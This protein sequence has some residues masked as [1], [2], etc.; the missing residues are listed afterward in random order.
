LFHRKNYF[1]NKAD[2]ARLRARV[3]WYEKGEQSTKYFFNLERKNGQNK[4]WQK[5][6]GL[7]GILAM[8]HHSL[9]FEK[10]FFSNFQYTHQFANTC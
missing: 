5:I 3:D 6:R 1:E 8:S 7:D 2:A 4:L 9:K 10:Y